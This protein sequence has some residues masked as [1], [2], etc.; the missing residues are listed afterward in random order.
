MTGLLHAHSGL[1]YLLLLLAFFLISI[2][3]VGLV[4]KQSPTALLFA[5]SAAFMGLLHL[6]I[7]L[8]IALLLMGTYYPALIGHLVMMFAAE[9][10][11]TAM[12]FINKRAPTPNFKRPLIGTLGGLLLIAG[13]IMAIGRSVFGSVLIRN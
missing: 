1:R 12:H 10:L 8:G 3:I 4:K 2:C 9:I 11:A 6:Q 7:L 13:G 5:S